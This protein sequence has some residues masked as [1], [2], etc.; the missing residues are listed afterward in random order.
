MATITRLRHP[1]DFDYLG[2]NDRLA[3]RAPETPLSQTHPQAY[4]I[5]ASQVKQLI[6][7]LCLKQAGTESPRRKLVA[8]I[9]E[10]TMS[11]TGQDKRY[12]GVQEEGTGKTSERSFEQM[13]ELFGYETGNLLGILEQVVSEARTQGTNLWRR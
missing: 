8:Y 5:L 4:R 13:R 3:G 9:E 6:G 7:T 1:R 10:R 11:P 2:Y 12:L